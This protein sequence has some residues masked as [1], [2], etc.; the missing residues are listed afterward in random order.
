M[1]RVPERRLVLVQWDDV[2]TSIASQLGPS[3][4]ANKASG[5]E[6]GALCSSL[7]TRK[8]GEN[9]GSG[10]QAQFSCCF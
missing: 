5:S 8:L 4:R 7:L 6:A 9:G 10:N 3:K 1:C 2:N